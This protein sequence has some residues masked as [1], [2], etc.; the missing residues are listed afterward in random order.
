MV[1]Q[2]DE[3]LEVCLLGQ[4]RVT[5][6]GELITSINH[7]R[8]QEMLAYLLL[9]RGKPVSRQ[10]L[11]FLF[12]PNSSEEQARTNLRNLLHRLRRALP[13][14]AQFLIIDEISLQ[15]N[16]DIS[17][18]LDAAA[19]EE[20]IL[21]AESAQKSDRTELL[22][23]AA[24]LY[25]GD[26]LPELYS[27]W[28]L[29][30]RER[31][32]QSYLSV[33]EMLAELYE[34]QWIYSKAIQST[35]TLLR[36]DPLNEN[37]YARLMR[38]YALEGN[39]GQALHV[40]HTCAEVLSKELGV[41]PSPAV[42]A[43]YEQL[44]Q[45][46]AV[47]SSSSPAPALIG[48]QSEWK[49]LTSS[50]KELLRGQRPLSAILITGE[51]GIGKTHLAQSFIGWVR[52]QGY[53]VASEACYEIGRDLAYAPIAS[54]LASLYEQD[55]RVFDKLSP[56]WR[57]EVSRLLPEL[58][59]RDA[60]LGVPGSLS[61]KWQLLHFYEALLHG[62]ATLRSPLVLFLDDIQWCDQE[63]LAWLAY[64]KTKPTGDQVVLAAT[65][66]SEVMAGDHPALQLFTKSGQSLFLELG[67][68]D[69]KETHL[70]VEALVGDPFETALARLVFH[71]S[72]GNP[73]FITEMVRAGSQYLNGTGPLP[74]GVQSVINWRLNRLS[75]PARQVLAL[76]SAIGQSFSYELLKQ[77]SPLDEQTLVNSLDE[78]WRQ[79]ILRE[80]G[81]QD[82][83]FS[84]D[85]L[86]QA[87][88]GELSQARRRLLHGQVAETLEHMAV[89]SDPDEASEQIA[90]HLELAGQASRAIL[91]YERA[92]Q[93][94]RKLYALPQA[95]KLLEQA[96][97]LLEHNSTSEPL[98]SRLHEQLGEVLLISGQY[99][100]S[101]QH[102][103]IA[104]QHLDPDDSA[105]R[106]RLLRLSAQT[107]SS[108]QHYSE[109][110]EAI[111]KA[112]AVLGDLPPVDPK[113]PLMQEWSETRLQQIDC[114]YF[115]NKP[116]EM[117]AVC[118]VLESPI[119]QSG[120]LEQRANYYTLRGMLNN[121]R[122]RYW[123]SALDVQIVRQALELAE[124]VNDPLL[125][126]R[127]RFGLGFNLLWYGDREEAIAQLD[128]ALEQAEKLGATFV[129]DQALA[130][131][132]I[133][134]RMSGNLE[135]VS[136]LVQPGL[137][138]AEAAQHQTYQGVAK[139]NLGWLAYH[140]GDSDQAEQLAEHAL[141]LWGHGDYPFEWL[142]DFPLAAIAM[143]R[144][145]LE[146]A[147]ECL[148]AIL[149]PLQGRLPEELE[150]CIY[151][152]VN[153]NEEDDPL[154]VRGKIQETIQAASRLGYL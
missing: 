11:A 7:A 19:F 92:A 115:Q 137:T 129:K 35:H 2:G 22:A 58:R 42:Q 98:T 27:D 131:L 135:M 127:K 28:L 110:Q 136:Q 126:A 140:Q 69:E 91:F 36:Q 81:S 55:E 146:R 75:E 48:R 124:Q 43:L 125:I 60:A 132:T 25:G 152:V 109:A 72:E 79:R 30:E 17:F 141:S 144:G 138:L 13:A 118:K 57:L 24:G 150:T 88:Y 108:Q 9:Q 6:G 145:E 113:S 147:Q 142:A 120:T 94:A 100:A 32:R 74:E 33:L 18:S 53:L 77:A 51:A 52:R 34:D 23:Q 49:Q 15:W 39:R 121:R 5:F 46:N 133:A 112:L 119:T 134:Y 99:E 38:L 20:A 61:E 114:L 103:S 62:F 29:A 44:L 111:E 4:F 50:W 56:T 64:L 84:H 122:Q 154:A 89:D 85:M 31:L 14:N 104:L 66:R 37:G 97:R 71:K 107:W 86:R 101:R 70:L 3:H 151:K 90:R 12:W 83:D 59:T 123:M 153:S 102:L 73:L 95:I 148:K 45:T 68:L 96:I 54:W 65:A 10:Q 40:Y 26:L 78:C 76:A 1:S 82:Y 47:Q 139:A 93:A 41:T 87:A 21:Q 130:Y 105:G 117:E 149:K 106:V 67:T 143:Q 80:K 8:L 16:S 128:Q 116:N 63:T